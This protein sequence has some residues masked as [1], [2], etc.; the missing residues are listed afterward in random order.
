MKIISHSEAKELSLKRYF[1]GKICK[2]GHIDERLVSN[3]RCV[4]CLKDA[5]KAWSSK[6]KDYLREYKSRRVEARR[7]EIKIL[8]AEY[9]KKNKEEISKKY[10]DW[11]ERNKKHLKEKNAIWRA[12][13]P[14]N[15]FIRKSIL[16]ITGNRSDGITKGELAC[17][18]SR[19]Q[20]TNKIESLFQDG[21]SWENYGFYGWHIDHIVPVKVFIENGITDPKVVNDL[22]NLQPMWREENQSKSSSFSDE[23]RA[24]F[25]LIL[26]KHGIESKNIA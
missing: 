16:R 5:H 9:R 3:R 17:G 25:E 2:N 23:Q 12:K 8:R 14:D 13:N 18:Y 21:M 7:E 10:S 20:L 1:T 22:D 19:K 6:N 24:L 15:V 4:S 11:R 26:E